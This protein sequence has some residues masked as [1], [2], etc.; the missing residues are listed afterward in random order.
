MALNILQID[1]ARK[2]FYAP[3]FNVVVAPKK[4]LVVDL[5]L[6][7]TSVQVNNILNAAD[8]F[9]FVINNAYNFSTQE[10]VVIDGK[11]LPDFFEFGSPVEIYMGY[12]DR[13]KLDLMLAGL[14]TELSTSFS[15]GAPQLTV[16]GYDHSYCLTKGSR[17]ESF[18]ENKKDSDAVR[19]LANLYG[20]NPK[21]EETNV[22]HANIVM[23]Q[24]SPAK[25]LKRLADRNGFEWFV[26]NKDLVF[27]TPANDER[28][29]IE[30]K[31]GEGLVSFSPEIKLSEQVSQVEVYGWNVQTKQKIVGKA[32]KGD[33]P[34]RDPTRASGKRRQS[35]AEY[36]Q[37]FC[38][39][40]ETTLRVREPV[41]SQQQADQRAK[42]ILKRRAEGFVGGSGESIGIPELRADTNVTLQGLGDFFNTTFYVRETTH[43]VNSSGY[44]TTFQVGDVTI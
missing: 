31:W 16:S 33:E 15:S 40:K 3:A 7:V 4:S 41:F 28:G 2:N 23:S 20:L 6:E 35:G 21:V 24:E 17:S 43:T 13:K 32:R 1:K 12:G 5:H 39:D 11:T 19:R 38:R 34:G 27:R 25:F 36:L 8:R 26:V 14:V 18:G 10:F 44:R 22:D 37:K 42:A 30:L 9:S 29:V